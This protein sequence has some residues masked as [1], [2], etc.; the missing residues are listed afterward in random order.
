MQCARL[1]HELAREGKLKLGVRGRLFGT[2]WFFS[3]RKCAGITYQSTMGH[4]WDR[5]ARR[6][7]KLRARLEWRAHG[8]VPIKPRGYV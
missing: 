5:S 7:E 1:L 3:C 4:R 6:V 8:T 2:I